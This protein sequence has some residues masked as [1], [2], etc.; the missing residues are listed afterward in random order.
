M[1]ISSPIPLQHYE[2][3]AI[4]S[5]KSRSRATNI[6]IGCPWLTRMVG[7]ILA[8]LCAATDAALVPDAITTPLLDVEPNA[9]T[10]D[11]NIAAPNRLKK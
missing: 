4:T 2:A 1:F 11:N 5:A 3:A 9:P 10:T 7:G 8:L 6:L